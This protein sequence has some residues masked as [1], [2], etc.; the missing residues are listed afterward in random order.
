MSDKPETADNPEGSRVR[1]ERVLRFLVTAAQDRP[2]DLARALALSALAALSQ[3]LLALVLF[4]LLQSPDQSLTLPGMVLTGWLAW[5]PPA[6]LALAA[7]VLPFLSERFVIWRSIAFFRDSL[8]RFRRA[9]ANRDQRSALMRI[10]RGPSHITRLLSADSRY[11]SLAYAGL[12]RLLLPVCLLVAGGAGLF[13]LNAVWTAF[14]LLAVTPFLLWQ[15]RIIIGG[16][17]LNLELREAAQEHSRGVSR[18][19]GSLSS[20][21]AAN[22]WN[23]ETL[24]K[25]LEGKLSDRYPTA[26]AR[27]LRL[28]ISAKFVSDAALF[29]LVVLLAFALSTGVVPQDRIGEVVIYALLA[30]FT[31]NHAS[32][33]I[34]GSIAIVTQLPFYENYLKA[35]KE[36]EQAE[37]RQ[38]EPMLR[39]GP[40]QAGLV[41]CF[42]SD[43]LSWS[44]A[45]HY[46][47]AAEPPDRQPLQTANAILLT[48]NFTAL[49]RD[50]VGALQL[51]G[52]LSERQFVAQFPFSGHRWADMQAVLALSG[53]DVDD[54]V[55]AQVPTMIR[56]L[57]AVRYH[58]RKAP[59]GRYVFI[60]GT[61]LNAMT[62]AERS[63]LFSAFSVCRIVVCFGRYV[64]S[65]AVPLDADAVMLSFTSTLQTLGTYG[66]VRKDS[67]ALQAMLRRDKLRQPTDR[68]A[69]ETPGAGDEWTP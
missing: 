57:A 10:A 1:A 19:V 15:V 29:S 36:I 64:V 30:R 53:R 18:L 61:D 33:I 45:Y 39:G 68:P 48:S 6:L 20:H 50:F 56:F 32:Q 44:L 22:R 54:E 12:L 23:A 7:A 11:A 42:S 67:S 9:L 51:P 37:Q 65:N 41:V 60:N 16:M 14:L 2:W 69:A 13:I 63:W 49:S 3:L 66:E 52:N 58:M 17:S 4:R 5:I 24:D 43:A 25:E 34:M 62:P 26:Y 47:T 38:A 31:M 8:T 40:P 46:I 27:R 55:W 28:G 35:M 21:F 59:T